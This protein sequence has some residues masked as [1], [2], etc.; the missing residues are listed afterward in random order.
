MSEQK[1]KTLESYR[2][3]MPIIPLKTKQKFIEEDE[4]IRNSHITET[5][6]ERLLRYK[7]IKLLC[8]KT[9]LPPLFFVF[10]LFIIVFM[11][12]FGFFEDHLTLLIGTLYP[13]YMSIRT[14]QYGTINDTNKWLCYWLC[15][16]LFNWVETFFWWLLLYIPLYNFLRLITLLFL[17]LPQFNCS[18]IVYEAIIKKLYIN[19]HDTLLRYVKIVEKKLYEIET[20]S[21][22]T[23]N[24]ISS[25]ISNVLSKSLSSAHFTRKAVSLGGKEAKEN[26]K[27]KLDSL[28]PFDPIPNNT[29]N[30]KN[31]QMDISHIAG[32][33]PIYNDDIDVCND[34]V[35]SIDLNQIELE[36]KDVKTNKTKEEDKALKNRTEKSNTI[37]NKS[38][39]I[40]AVLKVSNDKDKPYTRN[41]SN[42][43]QNSETLKSKS[44]AFN[45][46]ATTQSDLKK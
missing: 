25:S 7:E 3:S 46:S 31:N 8:D 1:D 20:K 24:I 15:F 35:D 4:D 16:A 40:K 37:A 26:K 18:T 30:M 34:T 10:I 45:S 6:S 43:I 41:K 28:S 12:M 27:E 17:Y 29:K 13:I 22:I 2:S 44:K 39:K 23:D 38:Y 19:Y 42:T 32:V 9:S 14:L 21:H 5:I 36:Q 33:E 11:V